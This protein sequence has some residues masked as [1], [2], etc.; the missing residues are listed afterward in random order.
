MKKIL[1][2]TLIMTSSLGL[3]A[4]VLSGL[5]T[6][7]GGAVVGTSIANSCNAEGPSALGCMG[8][9]VLGTG[10][11]IAASILGLGVVIFKDEV[12]A[13][14]SDI[15]NYLQGSEM[16]NALEG[17][18]LRVKDSNEELAALSDEEVVSLLLETTL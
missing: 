5:A 9:V 3:H 17:I 8:N 7:A 14:E 12:L 10:T 16:T 15:V 2:A 13:V 11:G 18:I 4:Q 6:T 1:L